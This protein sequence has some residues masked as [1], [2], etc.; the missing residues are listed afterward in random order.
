MLNGSLVRFAAYTSVSIKG[1]ST[2]TPTTVASAAPDSTPNRPI[3]TAT[4]SSKKFE[5]PIRD[6]GAAIL[7]GTRRK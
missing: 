6:A 4:A 5:V 1:T 3:A 2:K 7:W